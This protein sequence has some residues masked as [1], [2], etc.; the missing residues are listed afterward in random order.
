VAAYSKA[1]NESLAQILKST[2]YSDFT[3]KNQLGT[4]LSRIFFCQA[5]GLLP[6]PPP[7]RNGSMDGDEWVDI[8]TVDFAEAYTEEFGDAWLKDWPVDL[9]EFQELDR[10]NAD[11]VYF[12]PPPPPAPAPPPFSSVSRFSVS[13]LGLEECGQLMCKEMSVSQEM[14]GAGPC[15]HSTALRIS[16]I[17]LRISL[18]VLRISLIVLRISLIVPA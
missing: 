12:C 9:A 17:V 15:A 6:L 1:A 3:Q 14:E 11:K 7:P 10:V 18:I 16:L 5:A 4:E 13:S 8:R 2:P